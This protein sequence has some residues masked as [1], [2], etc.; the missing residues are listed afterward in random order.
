MV[1]ATE[2]HATALPEPVLTGSI[3]TV[4]NSTRTPKIILAIIAA[5]SLIGIAFAFWLSVIPAGHPDP[6]L[7]YNVFY[8]LF[9]RNE[10][11]GLAVV[12]LFSSATIWWISHKRTKAALAEVMPWLV[13]REKW[14]LAIGVLSV[15]V[16]ATLGNQI[17]FHNYA[18]TGD[19]YLADFQARIFLKGRIQ[20]QVPAAWLDA[21][22]V[23][24]PMYV[25]Y[26]PSTHT[27]TSSYLP[28][29]AAM[30]AVFQSIELEALLNPFLAAVTVLALYG[31][32]RNIWPASKT[33]ALIAIAL[34][35]SSS[36]FLLMSMTAYSMPAHLALN[37]IWLC[38]YSRPD[39]RRFYLAPFVG[40][41]ALGLHQ[42]FFHA[43]FSAPFLLRLPL[44]RRWRA[45]LVFAVVYGMACLGWLYWWLHFRSPVHAG[46]MLSVFRLFSP[47][48]P[49]IQ[50]MNLWLVLGWSSLATPLLV[51]LGF[52]QFLEMRPILQDALI[53]CALT[54]GFYFFVSLD[55]AHGWGY[56]YFH[57]VIVCFI[58]VAIVGFNRLSILVG[59]GRAQ[60][61]VLAGIAASLL[62]QFPLRC[63][64]AERFVRPYARTAALLHAMSSDIVALD[65]RDAWYSADLIRNDP[66][67][68]QRPMIVSLLGLTPPAI[69]VL[70]KA[71]S[72]RFITRDD[73]TR[74]GM[75]TTLRN[76]YARD[77]FQLGRGR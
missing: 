8:V 14:C 50:S 49:I 53:S 15:F 59:S 23:I 76:D 60:T 66:F 44:Q 64:Q 46:G 33:N 18:L 63:L 34:L 67:L 69:A 11:A 27:W 62:I 31:V 4:R 16:I 42:P 17:V 72:A 6:R 68:E 48:V 19:E 73:L 13:G 28:V 41:L 36:Q 70:E 51:L 43:F 54:F 10:A 12:A 2:P 20:A 9:A 39:R 24:K 1:S 3:A 75:F 74:L 52:K 57:G 71:G 21:I 55:Q 25:E 22:R 35:S 7:T 30:R 56:R 65:A 26:F 77:P 5:F 61:L 29:Y 58:L 32:A 47:R 45:T 40:V 37:T 38:L